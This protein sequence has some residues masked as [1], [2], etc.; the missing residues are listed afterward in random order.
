MAKNP[1]KFKVGQ[2]V[3]VKSFYGNFEK[4]QTGINRQNED[5]GRLKVQD[6]LCQGSSF[7]DVVKALEAAFAE[8]MKAKEGE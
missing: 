8:E 3:S 5:I 6:V 7:G 1:P 4:G 2:V